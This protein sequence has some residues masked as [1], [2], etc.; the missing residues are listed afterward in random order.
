MSALVKKIEY[1]ETKFVSFGIFKKDGEN[2]VLAPFFADE[3]FLSIDSKKH[4]TNFM[5]AFTNEQKKMISLFKKNEYDAFVKFQL[6]IGKVM[7]SGNIK[8]INIIIDKYNNYFQSDNRIKNLC[9]IKYK[10]NFMDSITNQDVEKIKNFIKMA[11]HINNLIRD[12]VYRQG[13]T[14]N[15]IM[16]KKIQDTTKIT[17]AKKATKITKAKKVKKATKTKK[18]TKAKKQ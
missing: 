13:Q 11:T 4:T 6:M 5:D 10:I 8:N 16:Y 3:I 9:C 2:V 17:K 7:M 12:I 18:T 1:Y 14:L 15:D